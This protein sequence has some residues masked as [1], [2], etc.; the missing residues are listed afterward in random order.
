[1]GNIL[2][3]VHKKTAAGGSAVGAEKF[4]AIKKPQTGAPAVSVSEN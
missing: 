1:M 2:L 4:R 3:C